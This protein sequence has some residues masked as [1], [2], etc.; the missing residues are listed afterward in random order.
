MLKLL[1]YHFI[2]CNKDLLNIMMATG[3]VTVFFPLLLWKSSYVVLTSIFPF[4][5][6]LTLLSFCNVYNRLL[7]PEARGLTHTLPEKPYKLLLS[8]ILYMIIFSFIFHLTWKFAL[9]IINLIF[10]IDYD[11]KFVGLFYTSYGLTVAE[12]WKFKLLQESINGMILLGFFL[13]NTIHYSSLSLLS[14]IILFIVTIASVICALT[15]LPFLIQNLHENIN[16]TFAYS[17]IMLYIAIT[18][19]FFCV[20]AFILTKKLDVK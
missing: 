3:I 7:G 1:K 5:Y 20:I 14:R 18:V 17:I 11:I 19:G 8:V 6:F 10:P 9:Y 12:L 13:I 2:V 15:A 16:N 4:V